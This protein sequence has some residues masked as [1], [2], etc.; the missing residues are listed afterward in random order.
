M[1]PLF[2][3]C[4]SFL[5]ALPLLYSAFFFLKKFF[6]LF[7]SCSCMLFLTILGILMGVVMGV[8]KMFFFF[9]LDSVYRL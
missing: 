6:S 8:A 3:L 1:Y 7:L 5:S 2:F 4:L 9:F